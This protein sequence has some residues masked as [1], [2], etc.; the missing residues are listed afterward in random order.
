MDPKQ[1]V[2]DFLD[3]EDAQAQIGGTEWLAPASDPPFI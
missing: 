3:E 1:N 2:S